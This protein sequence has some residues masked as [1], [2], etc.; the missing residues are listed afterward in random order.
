MHFKVLF[1]LALV[2]W[3]CACSD[4]A[5]QPPNIISLGHAG[6]GVSSTYAMNSF[7]GIT[8]CLHLGLSGS[9]MDVQMTRD[10]V[11]VLCHDFDLSAN[12]N[13]SG[14]IHQYSWAEIQEGYFDF[15]PHLQY[16]IVSLDA[17]FSNTP[18]LR[19]Y[20]FTFDCKLYPTADTDEGVFYGQYARAMLAQLEKHNMLDRVFIESVHTDFLDI[21][22][23][24]NPA[25]KLFLYTAHYENGMDTILERGYY[26]LSMSMHEVTAAQVAAARSQGVVVSVWNAQSA[27]DNRN[28]V[29]KSP[30]IIVTDKPA[31]LYEL[32]H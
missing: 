17:F 4:G 13:L 8:N 23:S 1:F 24:S 25:L 16:E 9:E 28:A 26:G 30:D 31:Y 20:F 2:G 3:L 18:D 21:L 5:L 7:E 11:L 29:A 14:I 22:K 12:T 19:S 27:A 6:M 10:S 15:Y 32:L